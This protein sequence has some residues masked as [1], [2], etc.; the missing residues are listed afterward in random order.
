MYQLWQNMNQLLAAQYFILLLFPV[1]KKQAEPLNGTQKTH[2]Q[3][4][5]LLVQLLWNPGYL[6]RKMRL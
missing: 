4:S 1:T 2:S 5:L 3:S 6:N